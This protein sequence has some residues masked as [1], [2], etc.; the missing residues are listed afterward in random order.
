MLYVC[1]SS[2]KASSNFQLGL[3]WNRQ[4]MALIGKHAEV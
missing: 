3:Y 4:E 2:W 1:I